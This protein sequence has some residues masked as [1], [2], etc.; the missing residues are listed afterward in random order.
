MLI[1]LGGLMRVSILTMRGIILLGALVVFVIML[2]KEI[3]KN[4]KYN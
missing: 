2:V 4:R 3:M 1:N